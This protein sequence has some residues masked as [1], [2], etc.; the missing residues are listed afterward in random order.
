MNYSIDFTLNLIPLIKIKKGFFNM[1]Y[2]WKTIFPLVLS[3]GFIGGI[4]VSF[5]NNY[6]TLK[7]E[8]NLILDKWMNQLRDEVS[9]FLECSEKVR[10][11]MKFSKKDMGEMLLEPE[12]SEFIGISYKVE[13]LLSYSNVIGSNSSEAYDQKLLTNRIIAVREQRIGNCN[14]NEYDEKEIVRLTKRI[15]ESLRNKILNSL[16]IIN[17]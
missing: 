9:N 7:K 13:L 14:F 11:K 4:V 10:L 2:A 1:V 17:I 16:R 3:G 5:I 15:L 12:F 8:K 6:F